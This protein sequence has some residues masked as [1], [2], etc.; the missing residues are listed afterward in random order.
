MTLLISWNILALFIWA[1]TQPVT[2]HSG[3]PRGLILY[4]PWLLVL[5]LIGAIGAFIA[6]SAG[7]RV[8]DVRCGVISG[9]GNGI[10]YGAD[11]PIR[12]LH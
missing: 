1:G 10:R 6:A 7:K 8:A 5:P 11:I 9:V 12:V 3:E 2:W 4:V